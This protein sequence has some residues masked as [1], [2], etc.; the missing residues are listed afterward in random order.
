MTMTDHDHEVE[1][2]RDR[3][4]NL[5]EYL[6][7]DQVRRAVES[8]QPIINITINEAP[9]LAPPAP[10]EP[11]IATKYAGHLVLATWSA[12][13]LAGLAIALIMIAHVLMT[14]MISLAVCSVA[15]AASIGYLRS[16]RKEDARAHKGRR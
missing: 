10:P 11:D 13:V 6:K 12:I 2:Y 14:M 1:L 7:G 4:P 3:L 16:L 15:V 8:G 5:V 9:R